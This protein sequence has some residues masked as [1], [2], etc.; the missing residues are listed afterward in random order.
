MGA[1]GT[2]LLQ[3]GVWLIPLVLLAT[4]GGLYL[5][6]RHWQ[7][8]TQ[9]DVKQL[10]GELRSLQTAHRQVALDAQAHSPDDPEPYGSRAAALQNH[11]A[12]AADQLENLLRQHIDIQERVHWLSYGRWQAV[13]GAP[14]FWYLLR[15]D[16][17]IVRD[18]LEH[19]QE[20][21]AAVSEFE[22]S[23]SHV[24]WEVAL[25]A[26][27]VRQ[28]QQQTTELMN[29][30]RGRG[31]HGQAM[32][33]ANQL[34]Q[35]AL[36][37]MARVPPYYFNADQVSVLEQADKDSTTQAHENLLAARRDL[38]QVL[39]QAQP[40]E[41]QFHEISER[42]SLMQRLL[43]NVAALLAN[44]PPALDVAALRTQF[45]QMQFIAQNLHA[46]L[47]RLEIESTPSVVQE[48]AHVSQLAEE[49]GN[50]LQKAHTDLAALETALTELQAGLKSISLQCAALGTH[51]TVPVVWSQTT[52]QLSDVSRQANAIGPARQARNPLQLEQDLGRVRQL[53]EQQLALAQHCST[54]EQQHTELTNLLS[55][56]ELA[57][58]HTWLQGAR[59][60][61]VRVKEYAPEN[62]PRL[63]GVSNLPGDLQELEKDAQNLAPQASPQ[64]LPE[65][66]IEARLEATRALAQELQKM[67]K[68]LEN[69]QARLAG[70]QK[71]EKQAHEQLITA[72]AALAQMAYIVR[73]NPFLTRLV[74]QELSRLQDE[75][76][77][78]LKELS[79]RQHGVVEKKARQANSLTAKAEQAANRWLDQL[80]QEIQSAVQ[81]LTNGLSTLDAIGPLDDEAAVAEARRQLAA[82]HAYSASGY[83]AKS[84]YRLEEAIAEFKTRSSYWQVSGAAA[85]AL[86]HVSKPVFESYQQARESHDAAQK[87][88]DENGA[89]LRQWRDWPPTTVTLEAERSELES[90]DGQWQSLKAS[91]LAAIQLV[92]QLVNL[93]ARYRALAEKASQKAERAAQEMSQIENLEGELSEMAEVWQNQ[94]YAHRD[95]P[96]V[97]QD[98][99]ALLDE[100]DHELSQL[101]RQYKQHS[102][103]YNQIL[104][105]MKN[106]HRKVRYYQVALDEDHSIDS[107]GSV[108][109]R[110]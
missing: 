44:S 89:W 104:Q 36:Q 96:E 53:G 70:I 88:M 93:S 33:T 109:R 60:L 54:I 82:G 55:S 35:Q 85:K 98:I 106:L 75:V 101:K 99:R 32:Q 64:P 12:S 3:S 97:S 37:A 38:E 68:R 18:S 51:A 29:R 110:R 34:E 105:Q 41:R 58:L 16:I 73:S 46:T 5:L 92:Q 49:M 24:S 62:W 48:A 69:I 57:Q 20:N 8:R 26:R 84:R 102:R 42:V 25:Q 30:L 17:A 6:V 94:W 19:A 23:L 95:Q 86:E 28:A 40:W 103:D 59:Q 39:A 107:S 90:L 14:Y 108:K 21:L 43:D 76:Q 45:G 2:T 9:E 47:G 10:R 4:I 66:E 72:E 67:S 87:A 56:A 65:A 50:Q 31:M 1:E 27:Q 74:T 13:V 100:I 52:S 77:T 63:D 61:L 83:T 11:L 91:R 71:D 7:A 15:K 80:N 78:A 79:D 81:Q 22:R